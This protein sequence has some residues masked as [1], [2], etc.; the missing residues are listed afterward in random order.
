MTA[1]TATEGFSTVAT[2]SGGN[3]YVYRAA[4]AVLLLDP[5]CSVAEWRRAAA[6]MDLFAGGGRSLTVWVSHA[7]SDHAR[8]LP[9]L[10]SL[11]LSIACDIDVLADLRARGH[12]SPKA[13]AVPIRR[14]MQAWQSIG[15]WSVW[16]IPMRHDIAGACGLFRRNYSRGR[17]IGAWPRR[18]ERRTLLYM[19]DSASYPVLRLPPTVVVTDLAI[20]IN[21]DEERLLA[22]DIPA[23]VRARIAR[24]HASLEMVVRWL[25]DMRE[26]LRHATGL[27]VIHVSSQHG[28]RETYEVSARAALGHAIET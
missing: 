21:H 23:A 8:L 13:R 12:L 15:E 18:D 20:E 25:S 4:D 2:G 19:T 26:Q 1:T 22:G 7:H 5:G 14:D 9:E 27:H 28:D 6:R 10:E 11:G 3:L 24:N 16:P 17:S